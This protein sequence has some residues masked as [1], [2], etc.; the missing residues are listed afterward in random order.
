MNALIIGHSHVRDLGQYFKTVNINCIKSTNGCELY[1][2]F[3]C[4]PG[5]T[6][7]TYLKN[8][9][10]LDYSSDA[11]PCI[12]VVILGGNDIKVSVDLSTV[13]NSCYQFFKLLKSKF[14]RS[15]II[16]SQV[17]LRYIE[18]GDRYEKH[19]NPHTE[20]FRKLSVYFN[21]WLNKQKFKDRLLCIRGPHKL[22][23]RDLYRD[24]VHFNRLG[25]KK[26][27]SILKATLFDTLE[28]RLK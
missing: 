3:K 5:A 28:N 23:C 12:I 21:S 25:L 20:E 22:D 18:A 24:S 9:E 27:V 26:F 8:P 2:R 17:E 19:G 16:A 15:Y 10:L 4:I 1:P 7:S 14:P 13:K 6:Y 11:S